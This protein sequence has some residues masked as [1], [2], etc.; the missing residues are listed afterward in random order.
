MKS[1]NPPKRLFRATPCET[2][3]NQRNKMSFAEMSVPSPVEWALI[4]DETSCETDTGSFCSQLCVWFIFCRS[5]SMHFL[6]DVTQWKN[7]VNMVA[8]VMWMCL[9][10]TCDSSWK[11][12]KGWK[13]FAR[14]VT[15]VCGRCGRKS[16]SFLFVL[17]LSRLIL[18]ASMV[19]FLHL[20]NT[21]KENNRYRSV[22]LVGAKSYRS[23]PP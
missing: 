16:N 11:M 17:P 18:C 4:R 13:R 7:I 15:L 19:V 21:E 5:T 8:T 10:S 20:L 14:L 12:M 9:T 6:G 22:S 2:D 23:M 3:G 1:G